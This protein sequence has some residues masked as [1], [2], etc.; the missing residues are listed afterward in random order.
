MR[1][2]NTLTLY[3]EGG[4]RDSRAA[5]L[6]CQ[7]A[8]KTFLERAGVP[9][10]GFTVT[11]CGDRRTAFED[12]KFAVEQG[13]NALLLVDSEAGVATDT[14]TGQPV[15]PWQHL[16]GRNGDGWTPP[17]QATAVQVH[18]MVP[19]MEAW[20]VADKASLAAYYTG[21]FGRE[22]FNE[23]ALPRRDDVEQ[24]SKEALYEALQNAT[25]PNRSKGPYHKGNHSF[26]ILK[27]LNP[28]VVA[29]GSYH[30]R[31][32]LCHLKAALQAASMAWLDCAEFT[33]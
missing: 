3:V 7:Q 6:E 16:A 24:V 2:K 21:K 8:F 29:R 33:A 20:L 5:L 17:V 13:E 32:L 27:T 25:R 1:T 14:G 11:A 19:T 28:Q 9:A 26:E 12:F 22:A 10:R 15:T 18:L 30:F 31:R 4:N 23:S